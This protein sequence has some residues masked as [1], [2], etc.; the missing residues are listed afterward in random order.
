MVE[1]VVVEADAED[2]EDEVDE[3]AVGA[4]DVVAEC[5]QRLHELG[6]SCNYKRICGFGTVR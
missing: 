6:T 5:E 3:A 2:Q 4:G 1:G